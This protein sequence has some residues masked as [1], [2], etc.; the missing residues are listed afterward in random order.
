MKNIFKEIGV[1][2]KKVKWPTWKE[3]INMTIY[4]I[5]LCSIIALMMVVLDL[6]FARIRDWF[7]NI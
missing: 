3:V 7:L 4:V 1:E 5:I 6:G 2:L